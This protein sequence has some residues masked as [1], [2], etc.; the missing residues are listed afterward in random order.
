MHEREAEHGQTSLE[1]PRTKNPILNRPKTVAKAVVKN[2]PFPRILA[3]SHGP[4]RNP[5]S[6]TQA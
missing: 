4:H 5:Q 1:A 6:S 2:P 3:D